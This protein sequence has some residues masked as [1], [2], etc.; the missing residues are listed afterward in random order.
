MSKATRLGKTNDQ[1]PMTKDHWA[2]TARYL[3]VAMSV[4]ALS[5]AAQQP[6]SQPQSYAPISVDIADSGTLAQIRRIDALAAEKQWDEAIDALRQL[7]EGDASRLV[8]L[9]NTADEQQ[10]RTAAHSFPRYLRLRE[11]CQFQLLSWASTAPPA[12][13]LYRQQVDPVAQRLFDQASQTRDE[14]LLQRVVEYYFASSV[15]DDALWRL[16]ESAW[17]QRNLAVARG[18]WERLS[19]T[20]R[21]PSHQEPALHA[22]AG[23]P[24]W[25]LTRHLQ[26]E[27]HW[28]EAEPWLASGS[29]PSPWLAY[30]DTDLDL[31]A[32]RARLVLISILEGNVERASVE[33]S[34]LRRLAP[35]AQGTIGGRQGR[36][37]ELLAALLEESEHWPEPRSEPN[38][39]SFG[40]TA[41][42]NL[43]APAQFEIAGQPRWQSEL[44]ALDSSDEFF[45]MEGLRV[46]E[47]VDRLLSYHPLVV[48]DT[49]V[50]QTGPQAEHVVAYRLS[51]GARLFGEVPAELSAAD[52][53]PTRRVAGVPRYPLSSFGDTV[54]ARVGSAATGIRPDNE[55]AQHA[56]SR[57][58]GLSLSAQ[59]K[60]V[61]E[62]ELAEDVW[63]AGWSFDGVPTVDA[64]RL[65][66]VARRRD[67]VRC[68]L[69]AACFDARDGELLWRR[70]LVAAEPL[71]PER[72]IEITHTL[73]SLKE[74]TLYCNTHLGVVAAL[75][76]AD[77]QPLWL[78]QYPRVRPRDNDPD[79]N[80]LHFF[81]DLTPC[82]LHNDLLIAAPADCDRIFTL[83]ANTGLVIWS[84]RAEQAADAIH[85]LGVGN[86]QLIASGECLY[87]FDL[88]TGRL[89]AQFPGPQKLTPGL[90]RPAPRGYGRGILAGDQVYWPTHDA[91]LIFEQRPTA[92]ELGP[93]PTL[94]RKIEL[95]S[96]GATGGNLVLARNTLLIAADRLFAW[97]VYGPSADLAD[98]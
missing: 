58:V 64:A 60:R 77:G 54:Y 85:L 48:G 79:R 68:E 28:R 26:S 25:L 32:V 39:T 21:F 4:G 38:W 13:D 72:T 96:R 23:R 50:V 43:A 69:Q 5:A 47:P 7:L 14:A 22:L 8:P 57:I 94:V 84:S 88:Y 66:V 62:L 93:Q 81:R 19:P 52:G 78:T 24:L 12:L 35:E 40:G 33:L 45:S 34:L 53:L 31:D 92:T 65:Y 90:A 80:T 83:D 82:L 95:I 11:F 70:K 75:R 6:I 55:L 20:L 3:F 76:A 87:W 49:V 74:R 51:D 18:V 27:E 97:D 61:V 15:G 44:P 42:R 59:G 63:G 41:G 9:P 71:A 17:E 16:G 98:R 89:N 1:C 36:F 10:N 46:A 91:I 30:P 2:R 67:A 29:S 73:L 86:G 37:V 56:T